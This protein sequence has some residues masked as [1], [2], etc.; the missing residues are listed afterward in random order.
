MYV[1]FTTGTT[2]IGS[3]MNAS[4]PIQFD[5]VEVDAGFYEILAVRLG[6]DWL[7]AEGV[8]EPLDLSRINVHPCNWECVNTTVLNE[9]RNRFVEEAA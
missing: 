6:E 9:L 8:Y 2:N 4:L 5:L 1:P 7:D 3:A